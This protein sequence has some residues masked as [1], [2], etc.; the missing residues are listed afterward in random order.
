MIANVSSTFRDHWAIALNGVC[1]APSATAN[2]NFLKGG[3]SQTAELSI[4][5]QVSAELD[6]GLSLGRCPLPSHV[7]VCTAPRME[8]VAPQRMGRRDREELWE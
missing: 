1:G 4:S 6:M 8:D 3:H 7:K 2:R 5:S